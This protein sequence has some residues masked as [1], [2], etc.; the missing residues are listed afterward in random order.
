[1]LGRPNLSRLHCTRFRV[2]FHVKLPPSVAEAVFQETL[3]RESADGTQTAIFGKFYHAS[4]VPHV[5]DASIYLYGENNYHVTLSF[6]QE[7]RGRPPKLILSPDRLMSLILGNGVSEADTINVYATY[8]YEN[9][10]GWTSVL[11]LPSPF[12]EPLR[13]GR[14]IRFTHLDGYRFSNVREGR[15]QEW[16]D[17]KY[18]DQGELVHEIGLRRHRVISEGMV[19]GLLREGARLSSVFVTKQ[20]EAPRDN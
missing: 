2:Y 12:N 10:E 15:A 1:M 3:I 14:G 11:G 20:E 7:N 17:I 5:I 4:G 9:S 8:S 19:R 18:T 16:I 13:P 6:L